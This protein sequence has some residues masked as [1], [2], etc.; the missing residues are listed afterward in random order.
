MIDILSVCS[1]NVCRSALAEL[2]LAVDLADLPVHPL[3][4]GTVAV[5]GAAMPAEAQQVATLLG[6]R[7]ESASAHRAQR[8][9]TD[10]IE[11]ADLILVMERAHRSAVVGL[12]PAQTRATYTVREFARLSSTLTDDVLRD[13]ADHGGLGDSDRLRGAIVAVAAQRGLTPPLSVPD[14]DD[15]DDPYGRPL[16]AYKASAVQL[17]PALREVER[18]VRCALAHY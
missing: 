4:A 17:V 6:V 5:P 12:A 13:A 16:D 15:V 1:G 10:L 9:T 7:S 2:L 14:D 11:S 18:V 8:L 3:S